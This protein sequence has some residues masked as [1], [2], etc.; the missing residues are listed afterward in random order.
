MMVDGVS[1]EVGWE[2]EAFEGTGQ[3]LQP[4]PTLG[5]LDNTFADSSRGIAMWYISL[6]PEP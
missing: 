3:D 1:K 6:D 4:Y 5:D 2:F